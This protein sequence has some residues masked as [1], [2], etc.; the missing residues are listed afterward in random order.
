[1]PNI[2]RRRGMDYVMYEKATARAA[3]TPAARAAVPRKIGKSRPPGGLHKSQL[4]HWDFWA[5]FLLTARADFQRNLALR[6]EFWVEDDAAF[7]KGGATCPADLVL[8]AC[9]SCWPAAAWCGYVRVKGKPTYHTH[10]LAVTPE[11]CER[12][13][14][15]LRPENVGGWHGL[16]TAMRK[17]Q[18]QNPELVKCPPRV[19]LTRLAT[20]S[21]GGERRR[22]PPGRSGANR[23]W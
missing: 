2:H 1:M 12:L 9:E 21:K 11:S 22:Q 16:D 23:R 8:A 19:C 20:P 7:R 5:N 13:R 6:G 10:L 15:E 4:L 17:V 3:K 18:D 14:R